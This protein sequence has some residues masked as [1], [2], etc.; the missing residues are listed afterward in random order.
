MEKGDNEARKDGGGNALLSL[1]AYEELLSASL[2]SWGDGGAD[3]G[4]SNDEE[5][6][7]LGSE[8]GRGAP[9]S[10]TSEAAARRRRRNVW[11]STAPCFPR[12]D[13]AES[14]TGVRNAAQ[15]C[16]AAEADAW[17]WLV[18]TYDAGMDYFPGEDSETFALS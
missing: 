15:G 14:E 9:G 18:D 10:L 13:D 17:A 8:E 6:V 11:S 7:G 16:G 4:E 5:E 1:S 12:W 2:V 3:E